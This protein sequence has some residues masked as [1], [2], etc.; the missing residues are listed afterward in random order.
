[1]DSVFDE[2]LTSRSRAHAI[3]SVLVKAIHEDFCRGALVHEHDAT[4]TLISSGALEYWFSNF[5]DVCS[6]RWE[7]FVATNEHFGFESIDPQVDASKIALSSMFDLNVASQNPE[8][9]STLLGIF[10][11]YQRN[12]L[13]FVSPQ[14]ERANQNDK[15]SMSI[16]DRYDNCVYIYR[17]YIPRLP[18]TILALTKG[19]ALRRWREPKIRDSP[20]DVSKRKQLDFRPSSA[21]KGSFEHFLR[22]SLPYFLPRSVVENLSAIIAEL[23]SFNLRIPRAVFTANLHVSSDSFV[24]WMAYLRMRGTRIVLSQHGGLNGQGRIPT[25][26]EEYELQIADTL[27]HWGWA[28][29]P[30]CQKIPSQITMWKRRRKRSNNRGEILLVTDCTYRLS[31]RAWADS[32][33]NERYRQMLMSLYASMSNNNQNRVRVRLHHDHSKYDESHATMWISRFPGCRLDD[34]IVSIAALRRKARLVICTTLGTSEI[35][36]FAQAIPSVLRLDPIVHAI[37]SSCVD[38]FTRLETL[39]LV[40]WSDQS[41]NMFLDRHIDDVDEWWL[42]SEVQSGVK[43]YLELFG[44]QSQRPIRDFRNALLASARREPN[45][46]R[47][48]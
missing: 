4:T 18:E 19:V 39:Q 13:I 48:R 43:E 10:R 35:E 25:R 37:R 17:T 33:D 11:A 47:T 15:V 7:A 20:F 26:G 6:A 5:I 31:R 38:L 14:E 45:M 32:L 23:A 30:K 44:H 41:L 34:G 21:E 16:A 40:H 3:N 9:N 27:F 24:I 42:S 28:E 36:Q 46:V 22:S 29:G 2:I 1:M 12:P 8:W